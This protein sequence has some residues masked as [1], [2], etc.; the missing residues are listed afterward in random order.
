MV[1]KVDLQCC[2]CYKKVKEVLCRIPRES[3][4][5]T[6]KFNFFMYMKSVEI[7]KET[8]PP[9]PPKKKDPPPPPPPVKKDP[10]PP[11]PPEKKV[12]CPPPPKPVLSIPVMPFFPSFGYGVCCGQCYGGGPCH[13][14]C[15]GHCNRPEKPPPEQ[16]PPCHC[17]CGGHCNP[18]PPPP[19]EKKDPPPPPPPVKKD[20]PPPPPPEKKVDCPPPPKPVLSIPVMPF[21]PSFGYGVCCGQCYGGVHAIVVVVVIVTDRRNHHRN[22][23]HHAIVV[24]VVIVTDR[25]NHHHQHHRFTQLDRVV[26]H[27]LRVDLGVLAIT[28]AVEDQCMIAIVV[29]T[30]VK[31]IHPDAQPCNSNLVMF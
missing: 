14:G 13:C 12:D 28:R 22:N 7:K 26:D 5:L 11:P 10:P 27:V 9:P 30:T 2:R 15:G 3:L 19:P 23:H 6:I 20:P 24:V 8:P 18:P 31:K 17:G 1:L 21:F 25:N 16:P 4:I 29:A